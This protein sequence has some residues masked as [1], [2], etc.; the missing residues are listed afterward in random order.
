M[1]LVQFV[2]RQD[3]HDFGNGPVVVPF[4]PFSR[5]H[6]FD[7]PHFTVFAWEYLCDQRSWPFVPYDL[8]VFQKNQV[9]F[10]QVWL[11][12]RPLPSRLK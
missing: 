12:L 11:V 3:E 8:F 9:S 2:C 6:H 10:S 7:L 4:R 5:R 1:F